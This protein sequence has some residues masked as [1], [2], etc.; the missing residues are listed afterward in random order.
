MEP[1]WIIAVGTLIL[2]GVAWFQL[3]GLNEPLR[4][5]SL[6]AVLEM[7]AEMSRKKEKYEEAVSARDKMEFQQGK[8]LTEDYSGF[9]E[10]FKNAE[11][12]ALE[13][14]LYALN[15]L[16]YCIKKG[17]LLDKDWKSEYRDVISDVVQKHGDT[18]GVTTHYTSIQ[19]IYNKWKRE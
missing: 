9:I 10:S 3:K 13:N 6:M 11:Q 12:S 17:Y 19:D 5:N 8:D 16:C 18:F 2:A 1:N 15:R 7:E 14:Y 4:I